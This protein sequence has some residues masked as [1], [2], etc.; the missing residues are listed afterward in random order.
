MLTTEEVKKI[1]SLARLNLTEQELELYRE[2]LS[3]ILDYVG[4]LKEVDTSAVL[5]TSQVTGLTNVTREDVVEVVDVD[6]H[7]RIIA[8]FPA[9]EGN[10]LKVKAIFTNEH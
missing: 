3:S 1:A 4:Q 6:E 2:Q 8:Q 9:R 5:P 7:Q 10:L